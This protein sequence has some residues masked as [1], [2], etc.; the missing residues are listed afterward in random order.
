MINPRFKDCQ[1]TNIL[2]GIILGLLIGFVL[3]LFLWLILGLKIVLQK[4]TPK[5]FS[6]TH[7]GQFLALS[8]HQWAL[9]MYCSLHFDVPC[10]IFNSK[11]CETT[12]TWALHVTCAR[13]ANYFFDK[14]KC[15]YNWLFI[16]GII[17]VKPNSIQS[18]K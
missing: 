3:G 14:A 11:L 18:N 8:K 4:I 10:M 16:A 9:V 6:Q 7:I 15:K 5:S 2:L 1:S 13:H 12:Q 17:V